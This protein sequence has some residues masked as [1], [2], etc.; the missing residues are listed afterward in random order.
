[1]ENITV[2]IESEDVSL[3]LKL[4]SKYRADPGIIRTMLRRELSSTLNRE[5]HTLYDGVVKRCT[6]GECYSSFARSDRVPW[7]FTQELGYYVNPKHGTYRIP[8]NCSLHK[9]KLHGYIYITPAE[10][11]EHKRENRRMASANA[12]AKKR[13]L[14]EDARNASIQEEQ[15]KVREEAQRRANEMRRELKELEAS[16]EHRRVDRERLEENIKAA[17]SYK[18]KRDRLF[19]KWK[20][21]GAVY[22]GVEFNVNKQG[23][24]K[25]IYQQKFPHTP[26]WTRDDLRN[27]SGQTTYLTEQEI[28]NEIR[29]MKD[30]LEEAVLHQEATA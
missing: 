7:R 23:D 6:C 26:L 18:T 19:E 22:H 17:Q 29:N 16:L 21:S 8:A 15:R 1:M 13:K 25:K 11:Q 24:W 9:S 30:R 14:E 3:F 4:F 27:E 2:N 10:L 28:Q 5:R 20:R 12:M